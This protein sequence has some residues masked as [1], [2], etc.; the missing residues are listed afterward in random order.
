MSQLKKARRSVKLWK[1]RPKGERAVEVLVE[2]VLS[3]LLDGLDAGGSSRKGSRV[4]RFALGAVLV[5]F[6]GGACVLLLWCGAA[7]DL[8]WGKRLLFWALGLLVL[9]YLVH[10]GRAL[11][12]R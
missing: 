1:N 2:L 10:L 11:I 4:L 12:K 8:G 6:L 7:M 3:L 9:W 5:L